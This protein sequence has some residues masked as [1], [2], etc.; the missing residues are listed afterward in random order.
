MHKI[1]IYDRIEKTRICPFLASLFLFLINIDAAPC[2]VDAK[3]RRDASFEEGFYPCTE[4]EEGV[5]PRTE[6]A[7]SAEVVGIGIR[8]K[9]AKL[10]HLRQLG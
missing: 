4:V 3:V 10:I 5:Y 2:K 6:V 9:G 1:G 8:D 7:E